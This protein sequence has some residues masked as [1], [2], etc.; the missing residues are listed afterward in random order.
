MDVV[1]EES[2]SW[3]LTLLAPISGGLMYVYKSRVRKREELEKRLALLEATTATKGDITA[4]YE[5][6]NAL[7]DQSST[8]YNTLLNTILNQRGGHR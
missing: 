8:Q 3:I 4:V 5:R 2:R 7:A 6:L 1:P